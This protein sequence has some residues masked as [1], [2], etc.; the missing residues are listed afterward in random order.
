MVNHFYFS[1]YKRFLTNKW[2]ILPVICALI[3]TFAFSAIHIVQGMDDL[4]RDIYS[5][6]YQFIKLD[7]RT[8]GYFVMQL[9]GP[10]GH[11][12]A[13]QVIVGTIGL[14][15]GAL[16]TCVLFSRDDEQGNIPLS[17][18]TLFSCLLITA[19]INVS[20]WIYGDT[21]FMIKWNY[22]LVP[23]SI[24]ILPNTKDS[25][26]KI[27]RF[28]ISALLL[29][30]AVTC[31]ESAAA[32][33][34][35][36]CGASLLLYTR[37][38][39]NRCIPEKKILFRVLRRGTTVAIALAVGILI[40]KMI[41]LV[42]CG[43]VGAQDSQASNWLSSNMNPL[44]LFQLILQEFVVW[45]GI[46]S[47][48]HLSL[49]V[50]LFSWGIAFVL[51]IL[52]F[53]RRR[54]SFMIPLIVLSLCP[55]ALLLIRGEAIGL[56]TDQGLAFFAAFMPAFLL[57]LMQS[58]KS[59][60]AAATVLVLLSVSQC[61][62]SNH[63]FYTEYR[64]RKSLDELLVSAYTEVQNTFEDDSS[65]VFVDLDSEDHTSL[66]E[67]LWYTCEDPLFDFF[68]GRIMLLYNKVDYKQ[69]RPA[70][71]WWFLCAFSDNV[72]HAHPQHELYRYFAYLGLSGLTEPDADQCRRGKQIK[73]DLSPWPE[74]GSII[75]LE[76]C[77]V[78]GILT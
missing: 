2:Y 7:G 28:I 71:F 77:I 60:V 22:F 5:H 3:F 52:S 8:G 23:L 21:A 27:L 46:G 48:F 63:L 55:I 64:C 24:L 29:G 26:L 74:E 59:L 4:C 10:N 25:Q 1:S 43:S 72:N 37:S 39:R 20:A 45:Y 70:P 15:L 42:L 62:F 49:A 17:F 58:K 54:Y 67:S 47:F 35:G 34:V 6:D 51:F 40:W 16:T 44:Q 41:G 14:G 75:N 9:L 69:V 53:V 57:I 50:N 68:H 13:L 56:R 78:V 36:I 66:E 61:I 31:F 73:K 76:D 38:A 12:D 30:F 18:Y 65:V 19:P 33:T 32:V 11:E